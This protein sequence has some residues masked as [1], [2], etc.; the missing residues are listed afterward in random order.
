MP[1]STI[2]EMILSNEYLDLIVP[3]PSTEEI[4][5]NT[6]S[7]Y[8]AERLAANLG[9]IHV[10]VSL[11]LGSFPGSIGYS[12]I[13]KLFTLLSRTDLEN[14]GIL[15]VQIQPSLGYKGKGILMGFID[16]G[17]DFTHPAFLTSDGRSRIL[18]IWD[19]TDQ[20]GRTPDTFSYGSE[21]T[22]NDINSALLSPEPF[23]VVPSVDEIGHG[24]FVSGVAAGSY[25]PS[26]DFS[27][28]APESEILMVKLKPAKQNLRDYFLIDESAIAYQ[29]TDILTA[30]RYL[31][32]I[33]DQYQ[34]P[35]VITIGLGTNQGDHSG[36]SPLSDAI[37]IL[38]KT[39]GIYFSC[40]AGNEAGKGHHYYGK[41]ESAADFANVE[42]TVPEGERGFTM[43]LWASPP[44]L[45]S[46][47]IISPLGENIAP[48][49][50]RLGQ[51]TRITFSVEQTV[52]DVKYEI[53]EFSSGGQLAFLRVME[54]TPGIW[55]FRIY[56][57]QFSG[58]SFHIWLPVSGFSKEQTKFL[59]PNP[60]TTITC[61]GNTESLLTISTYNSITK[62][63]YIN[64]SRGYTRSGAIKPD[65]TAPGVSVLGPLSASSD[66]AR[67]LFGK[68]TG[69]SVSCA[70]TAGAVAL[71]VNWGMSEDPPR[72]YTMREIKSL[73]IRGADRSSNYLYPN[74]EW[75]Y[76]TLNLYQVFNSLM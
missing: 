39:T 60:D 10:P 14:A 55:T 53:V 6:Y 56:A 50:P 8:G 67:I 1:E 22:D 30:I 33:A 35:I 21:Y 73:L 41:L 69:S 48:I 66:S 70:I 64:S 11:L 3:I 16:T 25:L 47:G 36:Y 31:L 5:K 18:R 44:D 45:F 7:Q 46:V 65:I 63:L 49:P 4:F 62:S 51:R 72:Y 37:T 17:I 40:A 2:R 43:E 23:A 13:P 74:R 24:T 71:L 28:A 42:V 29:E 54:P 59:N 52:I 27:G 20:T 34:R 61:P 32:Q 15:R 58:G 38:S 75:G 26:E 12:N 57:R 19:Q 68:R 9:G 76:G